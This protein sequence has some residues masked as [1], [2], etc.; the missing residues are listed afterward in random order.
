MKPD[1]LLK[2]VAIPAGLEPATR[3]VEGRCNTGMRD[4]IFT[5]TMLALSGISVTLAIVVL[6]WE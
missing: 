3:G 4:R 6:F 1:K 2:K 5:F